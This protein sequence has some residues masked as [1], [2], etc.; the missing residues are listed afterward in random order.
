MDGLHPSVSRAIET[1]DLENG[2]HIP[3]WIRRTVIATASG[4]AKDDD[5]TTISIT[6]DTG[7]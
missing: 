4:G 5:G 2:Q 3:V 6:G 1:A 7:E